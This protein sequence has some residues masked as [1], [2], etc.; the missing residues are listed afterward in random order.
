MAQQ[1][2]ETAEAHLAEL[3]NLKQHVF[4][5][6][7]G[8]KQGQVQALINRIF[9]VLAAAPDPGLDTAAAREE[10]ARR[11]YVRGRALDCH[12]DYSEASEVELAEAVR[13]GPSVASWNAMGHV[14]WKKGDHAVAE[15]CFCAALELGQNSTSLR[16]LSKL[17][18]QVPARSSSE[19]AALLAGSLE[20]AKAAVALDQADPE[21]WLGIPPPLLSFTS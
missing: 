19:K 14:Q 17:M 21:S 6:D 16:E 12:E 10:R 3:L 5:A 8:E 4:T 15:H 20:R 2:V 9:D 11:A 13:L 7:R 18:R 1:C